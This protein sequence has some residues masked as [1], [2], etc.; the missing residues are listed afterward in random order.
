MKPKEQTIILCC[1]ANYNVQI[2]STN[3][4]SMFNIHV[5]FYNIGTTAI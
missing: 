5:V 4:V 3:I 2:I 1:W